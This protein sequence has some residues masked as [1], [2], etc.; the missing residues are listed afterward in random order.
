VSCRGFSRSCGSLPDAELHRRAQRELATDP[1]DLRK[2]F[3][4]LYALETWDDYQKIASADLARIEAL[5]RGL[6]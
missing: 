3:T 4:G 6:A 5:I 1:D 2:R